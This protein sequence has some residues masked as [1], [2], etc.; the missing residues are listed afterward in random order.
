MAGKQK[1]NAHRPKPKLTAAAI[2]KVRKGK[3]GGKKSNAW[4]AYTGGGVRSNEPIA[5]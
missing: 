3:G 4:R 2:R 5:W 1:F